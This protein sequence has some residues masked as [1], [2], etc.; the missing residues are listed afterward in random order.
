MDIKKEVYLGIAA[1]AL[2]AAAREYGIHS[3]ADAK[4]KLGPYLKWV[5][6]IDALTKEELSKRR[7]AAGSAN[8]SERRLQSGNRSQS[9]SNDGRRQQQG[10]TET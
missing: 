2:Y 5:D 6:V 8:G 4:R 1:I 3:L 10:H 9:Q 7:T